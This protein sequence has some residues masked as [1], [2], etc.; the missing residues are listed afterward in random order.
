[1]KHHALSEA[2]QR[3]RPAV[4]RPS[5]IG[6]LFYHSCR[7]F[8]QHI[9]WSSLRVEMIRPELAERPGGYLLASTHLSHIEAFCL[10]AMVR[11]KIDWMTR[12]EFYRRRWARMFLNATDAFS[13]HRQGVPVS[14]IRTA[15]D[16]VRRGGVVGIFPEGNVTFGSESVIRGGLIKRGVCLVSYR[17]GV[18]VV[19]VVVLGTHELN[20]ARPWIPWRRGRL[21]MAF[22]HPLAPDLRLSP[23]LARAEMAARLEHAYVEL[24][25]ELL[26]T[27]ALDDAR[28]P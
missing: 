12:I 26:D 2:R 14:A 4:T 13:V 25:Q 16:R 10:S 20:C 19:P 23:K 7:L 11:R 3:A 15:I 18:P 8:A 6:R 28:I 17:T 21:W 27:F 22:G 5:P 1:M 24:Y 9:R